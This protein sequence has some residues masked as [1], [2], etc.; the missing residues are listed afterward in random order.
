MS[1]P[2][3]AAPSAAPPAL[4]TADELFAMDG[5]G[6]RRELVRGEVREMAP[7]GFA[8]GRTAMRLGARIGTHVEAASAGV[9]VAAET[10]FRIARDP[11]TVRPPDAAFIAAE[12]VPS[13][14]EQRGF[15]DVVPDLVVEVV[16][17]S[18]RAGEVLEK[19]LEWVRAG[20]RLVWVVYP[21]QRLVVVHAADGSVT[22]VRAGDALD[23]ADVLPGLKI[24]IDDLFA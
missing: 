13:D 1:A 11:D 6:I 16:S 2:A 5:D 17:P 24:A 19:A 3:L 22:Q 4:V 12:Q 7:A 8:H 9:V 20:V 15:P 10:G 18:D 14:V 23:G 21:A